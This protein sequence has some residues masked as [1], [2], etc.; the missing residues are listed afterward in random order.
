MRIER[1]R[2]IKTGICQRMSKRQR[3]EMPAE[4]ADKLIDLARLTRGADRGV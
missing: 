2:L 4:F 3:A 1:A